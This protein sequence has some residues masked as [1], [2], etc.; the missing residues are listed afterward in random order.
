MASPPLGVLKNHGDVSLRDRVSD[1]S[2]DG[3]VVA[4]D[5]LRGLSN[6]NGSTVL[7]NK[8]WRWF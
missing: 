5:E 8:Y 1:H 2:R 3:W 7:L 6:L 4:L